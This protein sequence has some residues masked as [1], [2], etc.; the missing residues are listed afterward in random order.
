[1]IR[2]WERLIAPYTSDPTEWERQEWRNLY[3]PNGPVYQITTEPTGNLRPYE[4]WVKTYRAVITEY[5][6]HPEAKSADPHGGPCQGESAGLLPR[7][8]VHLDDL[9]HIGKEANN[10]DD[11]TAGL[12]GA[13]DVTT[14]YGGPAD[15]F[16]S[17]VLPV[18][19]TL[20]VAHVARDS[21]VSER[22]VERVRARALRP[23][24]DVRRKLT[25]TAARHV[26]AE[27]DRL[28][29]P[30]PVPELAPMEADAY[31]VPLLAAYRQAADDGRA[32]RT[33][34]C[35]CGQPVSGR[36]RFASG[37]CRVRQHRR[38]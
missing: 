23:S 17:L 31:A 25:G 4:V 33:C 30:L 16:G 38:E 13:D 2:Y 29:V 28:G 20:P 32:A 18:L 24:A 15:T 8:P 6:W 37:A 26:L 36:Q 9:H 21:G 27:L 22:T 3:E 35:G 11:V 5:A 7:R 12:A 19:A 14:E 1:M 10:V 34:A